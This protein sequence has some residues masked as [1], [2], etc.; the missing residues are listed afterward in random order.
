MVTDL[1]RLVGNYSLH[2]PFSSQGFPN[3]LFP[4]IHT[5]TLPL[6][7]AVKW[8]CQSKPFSISLLQ[9]YSKEGSKKFK[10]YILRFVKSSKT[11][12]PA[13]RKT[14]DSPQLLQ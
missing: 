13:V 3:P 2:S 6:C 1:E 11:M 7:H 8:L 9:H 5:L 4:L 14:C 12:N 10:S